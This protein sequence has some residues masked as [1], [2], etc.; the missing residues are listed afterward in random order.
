MKKR[1]A[2]LK[3]RRSGLLEMHPRR[4]IDWAHAAGRLNVAA[5]ITAA[6]HSIGSASALPSGPESPPLQKGSPAA[7]HWRTRFSIR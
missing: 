1:D 2:C 6:M 5:M 7:C 3:L 4:Q